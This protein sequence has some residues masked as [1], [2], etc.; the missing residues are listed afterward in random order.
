[1]TNLTQIECCV[2]GPLGGEVS[3]K[4]SQTNKNKKGSKNGR[5]HQCIPWKS[6]M[7]RRLLNLIA[8]NTIEATKESLAGA[9]SRELGKWCE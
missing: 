2:I 9:V 4:K 1:M 3:E 7:R 6:L 5:H 8:K